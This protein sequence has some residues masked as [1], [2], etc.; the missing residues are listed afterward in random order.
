M[1][2]SLEISPENF[3]H[4]QAAAKNYMLDDEHPERR[5]SHALIN[6]ILSEESF[7]V[8]LGL[9]EL[10]NTVPKAK[11]DL[12]SGGWSPTKD[13]ANTQ[14]RPAKEVVLKNAAAVKRKSG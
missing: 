12:C 3:L 9:E 2:S 13:N 10:T 6:D 1:F 11:L 8:P 7:T 14:S 5:D 4:L